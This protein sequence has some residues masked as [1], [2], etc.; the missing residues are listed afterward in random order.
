MNLFAA[1]QE[2]CFS[3]V[4]IPLIRAVISCSHIGHSADDQEVFSDSLPPGLYGNPRQT[5]NPVTK[6]DLEFDKGFD[7]ETTTA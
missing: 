7:S 3:V 6:R 2:M 5:L 4:L 1:W